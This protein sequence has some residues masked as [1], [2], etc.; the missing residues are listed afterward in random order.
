MTG[1][2]DNFL[3]A[4]DSMEP[5]DA[6]AIVVDAFK[7]NPT[8]SSEPE[9]RDDLDLIAV[10]TEDMEIQLRDLELLQQTI[11]ERG[12]MSQ[13]IAMEA[14]T[15]LPD[16][17]N[18][19][20]PI[21]FFTKHP[22][23][24]QLNA[25]LEEID[26][27]KKNILQK[28]WDAIIAFLQRIGRAIRNFL[29]KTDIDAEKQRAEKA[30]EILKSKKADKKPVDFA[31]D[32]VSKIGKTQLA[33]I[34]V[35]E[36]DR[37]F[38]PTYMKCVSDGNEIKAPT[39][40]TNEQQLEDAVVKATELVQGLDKLSESILHTEQ[41]DS[42]EMAQPLLQAL[43]KGISI[44]GSENA[45]YLNSVSSIQETLRKHEL[46]I[47]TAEDYKRDV[48][49][50]DIVSAMSKLATAF[51]KQFKLETRVTDAYLKLNKAVI[52]V[53]N[54]ALSDVK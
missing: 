18:E 10:A 11:Q 19:E 1:L 17:I 24:T 13:S 4:D 23:R 40:S 28:A 30:D 44:N 9:L 25:A 15:L 16:F 48:A 12:G 39:R 36:E 52:A 27:G 22:S 29:V 2:N 14:Q 35:I 45:A 46:L 50:E 32:V 3:L 33:T 49:S 41:L 37:D 26:S 8:E 51:L 54:E 20:R 5:K 47:K 53:N 34:H 6:P 31:A 42:E 21:E 7:E 43:E 38:I